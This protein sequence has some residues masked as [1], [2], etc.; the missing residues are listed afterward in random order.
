MNNGT[1]RIENPQRKLTL[2]NFFEWIGERTT[3][4]STAEAYARSE[5]LHHR[6]I[7]TVGDGLDA[8][9]LR[10][11]RLH[12]ILLEW[13]HLDDMLGD[14]ACMVVITGELLCDYQTCED[15]GLTEE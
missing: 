8:H 14:H 2:A 15:R 5:R 7:E 13:L 11:R 10:V 6:A 12:L 1:Q 9:V 3:W 4:D